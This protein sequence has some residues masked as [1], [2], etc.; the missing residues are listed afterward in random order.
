MAF[1]ENEHPRDEDGKFTDGASGGEEK[2]LEDIARE[3]FPHLRSEKNIKKK[4]VTKT[5]LTASETNDIIKLPDIQ[6]GRS[7][8]AKARNWD[9]LDRATGKHYKFVEGTHLQNVEVFAGGRSKTPYKKA[10]VYA[11][12]GGR[13]EDWEHVKGIGWLDTEEGHRKAEIHW[14]QCAGFGKHD[15]FV[16]EWLD[17]G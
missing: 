13:V 15:F 9:V 16:K 6:I 14:S 4:N 5:T 7:L 8:G 10:Y 1:N 17:E 11:Q 12:K 3:I 2:S